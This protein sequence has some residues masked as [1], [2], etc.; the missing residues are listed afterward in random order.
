MAKVY[1]LFR[2]RID[3]LTRK[4]VFLLDGKGGKI[5]LPEWRADIMFH[6]GKRKRVV[7][8]ANKKEA[9]KQADQIRQRERE[10]SLG[11]RAAPKV[12]D[13]QGRRLFSEIAEEYLDWGKA[14][15]GRKGRSWSNEHAANRKRQLEFWQENL[16]LEI[17][18]DVYDC[19]AK[20]EAEYRK[21]LADGLSG[22]SVSH[23]IE[24]L[25]AFCRWAK[26]RKYLNENPLE[27]IERID[28]TPKIIRRAMTR[29]EVLLLLEKCNPE[30]KL[31]Y[32]TAVCS[33]LR[34]NELRQLTPEHLSIEPPGLRLEAAWTKNREND[35]QPLF[36]SLVT[37]LKTHAEQS[38]A[39]QQYRQVIN[40]QGKRA[41][42]M[43]I[44]DNPLLYVPRNC[45]T[46]IIKDLAKA[47]IERINAKGKLDFHALRTAYINFVLK[48]TDTKTLQTL[49]RHADLETTLKHYARTTPDDASNAAEAVGELFSSCLISPESATPLKKPESI[50][51]ATPCF[52]KSC[53]NKTLVRKRG[54]EP[55]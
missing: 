17:L 27:E 16:K 37:M 26:K 25:S 45:G 8:S 28:K 7:L 24:A 29:N 54:L 47:G 31:L 3:P 38:I 36:K 5:A 52:T 53:G 42:L 4:R 43:K 55:P 19:Q 33:G 48:L 14:Q 18:A 2:E 30:H 34:A 32:M 40:Q 39:K 12:S 49:A 10:I 44:P 9:Q 46:L 21:L 6:N 11:V 20:V 22:S 41:S 1:Q 35:F 23:V 50:K 13:I 51:T 15:G